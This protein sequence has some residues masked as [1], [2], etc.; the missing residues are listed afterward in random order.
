MADREDNCSGGHGLFF[1]F[2]FQ[3]EQQQNPHLRTKTCAVVQYKSWKS[4]GVIAVRY[5]A[6]VLGVTRNMW[7][8]D[9]KKL[10]PDRLLSR[11][12]ASCGKSDLTEYQEASVEVMEVRSHFAA[13]ERAS[14]D[15]AYGDLTSAVRER[16][17][18]LQGQPVSADLLPSTY[19]AGLPQGLTAAEGTVQ[20]GTSITSYCFCFLPLQPAL[21][22]HSDPSWID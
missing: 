20:K 3:V 13:T 14:L 21:F 22:G 11:V 7:A 6:C 19:T 16:L 2:F 4:G 18:K 15:K 8:D 9:A 1:V 12:R 5:E 17:Q 10:R